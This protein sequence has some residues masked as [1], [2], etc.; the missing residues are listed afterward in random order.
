MT[1]TVDVPDG[2]EKEIDSE[3]EKGRY[4]NKSELVRDAIRRLLEERSEV[5]R[6]ELNKEY[7]EEIK[8]RMKQVEEGEI[9]LDDMRTMD[10]IAEDEGLKE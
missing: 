7:A 5:E 9:G 2:L 6:A 8:R 3:V 1:L 10:E 4:Q